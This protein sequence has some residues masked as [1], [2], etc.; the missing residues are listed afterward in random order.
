MLCFVVS[1]LW[2]YTYGGAERHYYELA[3]ELIRRGYD[4]RYITYSWGPSEIP[5]IPIGNPPV[6]HDSK[7]RRRLWPAVSFALKATKAVKRA[8]C[9]VVDASIPYTEVFS[10]PR[11]RTILML[12]EFWGR[13]WREYFGPFVGRGVEWLER[14]LV[15]R[16]QVLIVPSNFVGE[17][18]RRV[19]R[20]IRVV[21]L[22]LR[23]E[24]YL[25]YRGMGK[26]FD[27]A[28]VSRL[29]PYK[30]V[31]EALEALRLVRRRLR[32]AVVGDGP[33][34]DAVRS[35]AE[36]LDHS[37]SLFFRAPEEEKRRILT[38]SVYYLHMSTA[39]GFSIST[40]EAIALGAYP[41]VLATEYNA[42][43]ELIKSLE[44]G[45]VVSSLR[46][47]AE[48]I[49]NGRASEPPTAPLFKYHIR[50]VV[51]LYETILREMT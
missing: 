11:T 43:V 47:A 7:G 45:T 41:I 50:S 18:V 34:R 12:F 2:P 39:E 17:R 29:V 19:R 28:I 24:E 9:K 16:P 22:G 44:Y 51:D 36:S 32:V 38:Q 35:L 8:G 23:L 1:N 37:V 3:L 13:R 30:G 42:A 15:L 25:K 26:V 20:D 27:V 6:F 48:I 40:L 4:V 5:L 14:R 10:L 49:V 21:P 33:L 31:L 46:E